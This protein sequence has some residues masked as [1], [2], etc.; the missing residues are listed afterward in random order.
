[1]APLSGYV[2][3][4][5]TFDDAK[6]RRLVQI[7]KLAGASDNAAHDLV[8]QAQLAVIDLGMSVE[9][10]N[11]SGKLRDFQKAAHSLAQQWAAVEPE[12]LRQWFI[13][14]G[15]KG[16]ATAAQRRSQFD[17][18]EDVLGDYL[19][20]LVAVI[21]NKIGE[22]DSAKR[23]TSP[24]IYR[25]VARIAVAWQTFTGARPTVTRNKE[26]V[27]GPQATQFQ[28]FLR[29]VM[30]YPVGEAIVREVIED[31]KRETPIG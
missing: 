14:D 1:M 28:A 19:W 12:I 18:I 4:V 22:L 8:R 17:R 16:A 5:A 23:I 15:G 26:A 10:K 9:D 7:A 2:P 27:A 21:G 24:A 25:C 11:A 20:H 13:S 30:L 29:E 31:L 6:C 3:H